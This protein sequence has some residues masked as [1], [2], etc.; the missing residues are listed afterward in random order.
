V[1]RR[2]GFGGS[3][4]V[5]RAIAFA[6][7][8]PRVVILTT[9]ASHERDAYLAAIATSARKKRRNIEVVRV[10]T[11]QEAFTALRK[12][13]PGSVDK[14]VLAPDH[15]VVPDGYPFRIKKRLVPSVKYGARVADGPALARLLSHAFFAT[16][17]PHVHLD[18]CL[19]MACTNALF[20][21]AMKAPAALKAKKI[22]GALTRSPRTLSGYCTS[23]VEDALSSSR[24]YVLRGLP[25]R[26]DR[27]AHAGKRIVVRTASLETHRQH[28]VVARYPPAIKAVFKLNDAAARAA[29]EARRTAAAASDAPV[30]RILKWADAEHTS[31]LARCV[32]IVGCWRYT[33][34]ALESAGCVEYWEFA[35]REAEARVVQIA[36]HATRLSRAAKT[37]VAVQEG[38]M[39]AR[40]KDAAPLPSSLRSAPSVE[41]QRNDA[42]KRLAEARAGL[43]EAQR[44]AG[45]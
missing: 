35:V 10:R 37:H 44:K 27:G 9:A 5:R 43:A 32:G 23:V 19:V 34:E 1:R 2:T 17:I 7:H 16:R 21:A 13:D 39:R 6:R 45:E 8:N 20:D 14:L 33:V 26:P 4:K 22:G 12:L 18:T 42:S 36:A 29:E 38:S 28:R 31:V 30:D 15:G 41:Q 24:A 11:F 40:R 25:T 3:S